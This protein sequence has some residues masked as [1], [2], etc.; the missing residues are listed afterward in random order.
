MQGKN[1]ST[2]RM[3]IPIPVEEEFSIPP[4]LFKTLDKHTKVSVI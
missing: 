2:Q 3:L 4:D 1:T